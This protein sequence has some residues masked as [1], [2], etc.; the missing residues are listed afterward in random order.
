MARLGT[1]MKEDLRT[2]QE[3][4]R[5]VRKNKKTTTIQRRVQV[6][7]RWVWDSVTEKVPTERIL[8][9]DAQR[10][11]SYTNNP[12]LAT[13]CSPRGEPQALLKIQRSYTLIT[14]A[15]VYYGRD[16][17]GITRWGRLEDFSSPD[18]VLD[19]GA[20]WGFQSPAWR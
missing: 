11:R 18:I 14:K 15:Q 19:G 5:I 17:A 13:W 2:P 16:E 12:K 4:V 7:H 8:D 6:G 9:D 3:E 20:S 10:W 1:L